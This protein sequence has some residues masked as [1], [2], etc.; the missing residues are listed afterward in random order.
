MLEAEQRLTADDIGPSIK[1]FPPAGHGPTDHFPRVVVSYLSSPG[2]PAGSAHNSALLSPVDSM[3]VFGRFFFCSPL[4]T[5]QP[6]SAPAVALTV[7]VSDVP[8]AT[9]RLI[10]QLD[11]AF[12]ATHCDGFGLFLSEYRRCGEPHLPAGY[13]SRG[14]GSSG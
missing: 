8:K 11:G 9:H 3:S 4:A 14:Q 7:H 5:Y 13:L 1:L 6:T 2:G 10:Y 12:R